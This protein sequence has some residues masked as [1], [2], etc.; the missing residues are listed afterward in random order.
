MSWLVGIELWNGWLVVTCVSFHVSFSPHSTL[1]IYH[2]NFP[3]HSK[4]LKEFLAV[5]SHVGK[6]NVGWKL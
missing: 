5:L 6:W 1:S 2:S 4:K 3:Y